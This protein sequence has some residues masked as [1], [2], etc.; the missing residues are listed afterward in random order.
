[1]CEAP[2]QD[3][4][5]QDGMKTRQLQDDKKRENTGKGYDNY[6]AVDVGLQL[7]INFV[8]GSSEDYCLFVLLLLLTVWSIKCQPSVQSPK[9]FSCISYVT[10]KSI[11]PLICEAETGETLTFML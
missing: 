7:T 9:M 4:D 10:K 3:V 8:I 6:Q 1:M 11:N 5:G 2:E